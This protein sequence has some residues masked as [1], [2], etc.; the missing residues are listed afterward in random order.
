MRILDEDFLAADMWAIGVIFVQLMSKE[1]FT[2]NKDLYEYNMLLDL[3][4]ILGIPTEDM[5]PSFYKKKSFPY[6]M[7]LVRKHEYNCCTLRTSYPGIKSDCC[8][9]FLGG[10]FQFE[11]SNRLNVTEALSH[12]FL[13]NI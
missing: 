12:P 3:C 13:A 4:L 9:S 1:A 7:D 6:L 5:A 11:P 10:L 8:F 2:K